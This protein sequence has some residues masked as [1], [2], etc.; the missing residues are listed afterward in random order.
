MVRFS[1][2]KQRIII[3]KSQDGFKNPLGENISKWVPLL[4]HAPDKIITEIDWH[5]E[6]G[7]P[8]I[9][10][11]TDEE[12]IEAQNKYGVWAKVTPKS[13][14]ETTEANKIRSETTYDIEI[15]YTDV[16][17]T[18]MKILFRKRILEVVSV[19]DLYA[20]KEKTVLVC[21][22]VDVNGK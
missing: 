6:N 5:V 13:G 18:D 21:T 17:K 3:L 1:E 10:N 7:E 20:A 9:Q 4:P 14:K 16:I 19:L 15:R 11:I 22:E 12:Y 8:F 2:L